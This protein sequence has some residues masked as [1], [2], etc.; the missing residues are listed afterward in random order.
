[1]SVPL[2]IIVPVYNSEKYLGQCVDSILGEDYRDYELILVDDGSSDSSLAIMRSYEAA[3]DRVRVIHQDNQGQMKATLAGLKAACGEFVS[4]ID[5]D[6]YITPVMHQA[7]MDCVASSGAD[8]VTMAGESFA[9]RRHKPFCDSLEAGVYD[10][11]GIEDYI[12]PNLFSNHSLYGNRG[13]QSQ[14]GLKLF[15]RDMLMEVYSR[16]PTDIEMGEDLLTTYSYVV[17]CRRI[18]IMDKS[19]VGYMYRVNPGSVSWRYK[20]NLFERSMKL[21]RTLRSIEGVADDEHFQQ[22]VDYEVCF[23]TINA[24]L[25]EFL[26]KSDRSFS[27]RR[28]EAVRI[29]CDDD[30]RQA[31]SRIDLRQVRNPNRLLLRVLSGGSPLAIG[32]VGGIISFARGLITGIFMVL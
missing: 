1:M 24:F 12:I 16:I 11:K 23:F 4:M 20:R 5:S 31:F 8:L 7:M 21:C 30:F 19:V 25:N 14:K 22:E 10:R 13:M 32:V 29:A 9:G 17:M 3:D 2:S 18:V 26:M 27:A 15:R 6:D 28:D